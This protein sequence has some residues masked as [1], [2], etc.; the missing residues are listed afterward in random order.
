MNDSIQ[1]NI[2]RHEVRLFD[3]PI[4]GV[5]PDVAVDIVEQAIIN[6]RKLHIG[7]V[8]AAKIVNM[9]KN[10]ELRDSVLESDIIFADGMS[11]VWASK[12]LGT[13]LPS[14][15]T[16]IDLM[17]GLLERAD[18]ARYRVYLLG[19]T[20]EVLNKV[21]E[22]IARDYPGCVVA[23]LHNGY[24]SADEEEVIATDIKRS[25]ADIL[26]VA[27][28]SPKKEN[29]MARWAH[30]ID[31]PI[32]HGVGGS[33]DVYAGKVKRAPILWQKLGL[34]WLYRV[35]QEPGR[36]WKRYLFTNSEFIS[37]IVKALMKKRPA[38]SREH[39]P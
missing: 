32:C 5:T 6:R 13:P 21:R 15:V 17:F 10:P 28:T 3:I 38:D 24:F 31:A 25:Q 12:I 36:M 4:A 23:G 16:G 7:V 33:F 19:A 39:R 2:D 11:V 9:G 18:R 30:L 29:F 20:D 35:I 34:E 1:T 22:N 14:R 8:N 26:L 27:I 37:M